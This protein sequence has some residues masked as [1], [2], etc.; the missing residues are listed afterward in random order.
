MSPVHDVTELVQGF[1]GRSTRH[2]GLGW[3][4]VTLLRGAD[5][6]IL[7]DCGSFGMRPL[8][9]RR[10]SEHGVDPPTVTDILLTHAHYDH[11]A[12]YL[13]FPK[14]RV[15]ISSVELDWAHAQD[16][17]FSPLPEL[18]VQDLA[19]NPRTRRID[20]AADGRADVLP[21]IEAIAA[22]GHTPGSL[23]YRVQGRTAPVIFT[24]DA[25]KNR[26]ELVSGTADM[27][28]GHRASSRSI[29]RIRDLFRERPGT[30]LIPGHDAAMAWPDD[31]DR[32]IRLAPVRA[33]LQIWPDD[34]LSLIHD[35]DLTLPKD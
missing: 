31:V 32:P 14:A 1:P 6:T 24:G 5:R 16:P 30:V 33:G 4:S 15:H 25:A 3:S 13:L 29:T 8:L 23:V 28:L 11:A 17:A 7:V 21:G 34:D 19:T 9:A 22:S 27:S 35:V 2:G 20:T 18:Y 12:N 26:A 10:L